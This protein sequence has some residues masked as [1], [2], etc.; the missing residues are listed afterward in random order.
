MPRTFTRI[1][2]FLLILPIAPGV[3]GS[4]PEK[5]PVDVLRDDFTALYAG[6]KSAHYN[7]YANRSKQDYDALFENTLEGID[8]PMTR[9][10]ASLVFQRFV[11][12]GN[13][14]HARID[15]D[16][17]EWDAYQANGGKVFPIY[18]RIV[19]GRSFVGENYSGVQRLAPSEIL[20]INGK[21]MSEWLE[22]TSRNLSADTPYI[23]HS[24][25]E[26][27]FPMYLWQEA[28][29]VETFDIEFRDANNEVS[30]VRIAALSR[31]EMKVHFDAADDAFALDSTTREARMLDHA[32]A[33]LRP[34]PFYNAEAPESPWDNTGFVRFIDDAFNGFLDAGAT[35]LIIDLRQNPGGDNSFSD[36]MV[37]WFAEEPF[38]FAS[39]FRVRSSKEARASNQARLD[40][41]PGMTEGASVFFGQRYATVP[42]GDTFE[43][44]IPETEPREGTRFDGDVYVL[45]DRHSY[46]NAVTVAAMVQDYGFGVILG[47]KT[48][49]MA[50]TYGAMETFSL[51]N[52]GIVVGFPK[53]HIVR[54]SGELR[55]DGVTPD[56]SIRSPIAPATDDVVLE[57]ALEYLKEMRRAKR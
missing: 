51:P 38:C 6:L 10:E 20:S 41:H 30:E 8:T 7:L 39:S 43:Y 18:L 50:T 13:V 21:P 19:D 42:Y 35:T 37:A 56:V 45:I 29:P 33:Y 24:M 44:P 14:A 57:A 46:S 27:L 2:A 40:S 3:I 53:A 49:D 28:G 52:T 23:A 17:S 36:P 47:E 26:F 54:P 5:I 9:Q 11:A 32:I 48:S 12:Y 22:L 25:L 4:E 55:T 34:G 15:Y 31:E 16:R 1:I